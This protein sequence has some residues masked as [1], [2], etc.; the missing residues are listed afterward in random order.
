MGF[1]AILNPLTNKSHDAQL[2]PL[3]EILPVLPIYQGLAGVIE[4]LHVGVL[5]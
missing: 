4:R 3:H 2:E 1:P 5:S